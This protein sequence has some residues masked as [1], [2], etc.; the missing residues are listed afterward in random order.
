MSTPHHWCEALT[1]HVLSISTSC[2]KHKY[3]GRISVD[4]STMVIFKN[5][6]SH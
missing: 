6:K 5:I 4:T 3:V 1:R 2:A